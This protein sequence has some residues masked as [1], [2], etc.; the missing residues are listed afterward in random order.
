MIFS[1]SSSFD[2]TDPDCKYLNELLEKLR[3]DPKNTNLNQSFWQTLSSLASKT[4]QYVWQTGKYVADK[5]ND[6]LNWVGVPYFLKYLKIKGIKLFEWFVADPKV[7]FF[8]LLTLKNLK[9]RLCRLIGQQ[10]GYYGRETDIEWIKSKY[11]SITGKDPKPNSTFEDMKDYLYEISGPI[12]FDYGAKFGVQ[13]LGLIWDK[14]LSFLMPGYVT[15]ILG[16]FGSLIPGVGPILGTIT[17]MFSSLFGLIFETVKED[18]SFVLEQSIYANYAYNSFSMLF[19][20]INPLQCME[21][22]VRE[23]KTVTSPQQGYFGGLFDGKP[24]KKSLKK[25]KSYREHS[26]KHKKKSIKKLLSRNQD[27]AV[28]KTSVKKFKFKK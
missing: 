10:I 15:G 25:R 26:K 6:F 28:K 13:I 11:K 22:M 9:N 24:I 17:S 1:S 14:G 12:I 20:I 23:L 19:Q 18:I 27:I 16:S 8:T 2:L 4:G 3:N 5:V 21:N 7:A